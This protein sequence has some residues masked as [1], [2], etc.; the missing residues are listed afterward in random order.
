MEK[1]QKENEE[2]KQNITNLLQENEQLRSMVEPL[3]VR[4]SSMNE[5]LSIQERELVKF[6]SKFTKG[7]SSQGDSLLTKWREN[8]IALLAQLKSQEITREKEGRNE[9]AQVRLAYFSNFVWFKIFQTSV[10]CKPKQMRIRIQLQTGLKKIK[11]NI[12]LSYWMN[13]FEQTS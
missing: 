12:N 6:Q 3:N 5:I 4:L 2:A 11:A 7:D 9:R 1:L 10:I 13:K 8:V